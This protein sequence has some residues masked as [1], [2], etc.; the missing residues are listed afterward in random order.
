[1]PKPPHWRHF[2]AVT[3][4]DRLCAV[5]ITM[6][7]GPNRIL[8]PLQFVHLTLVAKII[9][10]RILSVLE[11]GIQIFDCFFVEGISFGQDLLHRL[12]SIFIN[13]QNCKVCQT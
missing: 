1:M 5:V 12:G 13:Q 7:D 11:H 10:N 6:T 9:F 3:L 4:T 8:L 2:V